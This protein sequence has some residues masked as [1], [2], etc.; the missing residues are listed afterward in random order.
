MRFSM[1]IA[2][3]TVFDHPGAILA[4]DIARLLCILWLTGTET[5]N[6]E[7]FIIAILASGISHRGKLEKFRN[8]LFAS[9]YIGLYI[10]K[11]FS[12]SCVRIFYYFL[13][14]N[15][16]IQTEET[17]K[18]ARNFKNYSF[19]FL[20]ANNADNYNAKYILMFSLFYQE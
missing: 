13:F 20:Y 17:R 5:S 8:Y 16:C 12:C 1:S 2:R 10:F 7:R 9:F 6:S 3:H 18:V 4:T 19:F 11:L 15:N 14:V